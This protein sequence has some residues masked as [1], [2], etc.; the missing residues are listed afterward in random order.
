[1]ADIDEPVGD[2]WLCAG[3]CGQWCKGLPAAHNGSGPVCHDCEQRYKCPNCGRLFTFAQCRYRDVAGLIP[4]H[5][6]PVPCRAVCAGSG[7][8]PRD[9][10]DRRPLWK[11]QLNVF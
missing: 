6:F 4:T 1:M 10:N 11:D 3:Q 5:D 2:F 7:Q 9:P 8:H